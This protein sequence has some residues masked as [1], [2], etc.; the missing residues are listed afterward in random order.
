MDAKQKIAATQSENWM[1]NKAVHYNQ[2]ANLQ[3]KEFAAVATSFPSVPQID[4]VHQRRLL[5][6]LERLSGERGERG[7]ALWLWGFEPQFD[8]QQRERSCKVPK[9]QRALGSAAVRATCSSK[10]PTQ[11]GFRDVRFATT[12][13]TFREDKMDCP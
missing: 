8:C 1:I 7:A 11:P 4:A 12:G 2:W 9:S 10:Q 3:P 5:G 6:V 13:V